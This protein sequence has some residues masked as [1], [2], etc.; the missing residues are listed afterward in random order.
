MLNS[1]FKKIIP[2]PSCGQRSRVPVK[3]GKVLRITCPSCNT[4]FE[5]KFDS[6][7]NN[8]SN[9]SNFR[10]ENIIDQLKQFPKLPFQKKLTYIL[11]LFF[12]ISLLKSCFQTP[13]PTEFEGARSKKVYEKPAETII[14][15]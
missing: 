13:A 4:L 3:P 7:L 5:I 1:V 11:A 10:F 9:L 14:N 15:L 8:L 12:A 6:P 2:C